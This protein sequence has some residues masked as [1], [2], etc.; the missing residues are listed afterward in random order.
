MISADNLTEIGK[1]IKTHGIH[2]ELNIEADVDPEALKCLIFDMDGIFVPFFAES[3]RSRGSQSWLVTLDGCENDAQA[4]KFVGKTIY[5]EDSE[6]DFLDDDDDDDRFYIENFIGYTIIDSDG[7]T[8]GR[9]EDIDDSTANVLFV[10]LR[11]DDSVIYIPVAEEFFVDIDNDNQR[12][13]LDLPQGL[14]DL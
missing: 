1:V 13:T 14:I 4:A 11:Q 7:A 6:L 9:V 5:A 8:I 3:C 2:G 10:V 12:L